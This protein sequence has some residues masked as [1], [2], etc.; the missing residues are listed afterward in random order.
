MRQAE[1]QYQ[2]AAATVPSLQRQ[3]AQQEN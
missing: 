3:I 1:S 2:I